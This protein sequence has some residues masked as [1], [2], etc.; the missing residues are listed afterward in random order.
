MIGYLQGRP[1]RFFTDHLILL[2]QGVGYE[3]HCSAQTLTDLEGK[4]MVE[5]WVHTHVRE[6]ALQLFGF[7]S[8]Q[9]RGL[10]LSLLKV[11]GIG[12][13][14]AM[15]ILSGARSAQII[16]WIE[17]ANAGALSKL[18]KIGKKSAEQIVLTLQGKLVRASE[19]GTSGRFTARSQI[20]S[21]LVNLGFRLN[22][23]ERVVDQ[24]PAETDFESGLRQGLAGLTA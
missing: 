18:P 9:E 8:E 5:V 13:K 4:S 3:V 7:S 19:S 1:L 2:V 15:Q 10:F 23:V 24:M 20:V 14:S 16:E 21:A 11:N 17:G 22:D 12:P 6:D